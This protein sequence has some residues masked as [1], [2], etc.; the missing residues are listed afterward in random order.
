VGE[1]IGVFKAIY[2][3]KLSSIV[4]FFEESLFPPKLVKI[5]E[6]VTLTLTPLK[7]LHI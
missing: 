6:N 7:V 3:K 1:N 4:F 5:A 2:A